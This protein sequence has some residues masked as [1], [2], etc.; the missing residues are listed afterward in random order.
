MVFRFGVFEADAESGQLRKSGVRV[1]LTEQA[2]QVL[3]ALLERPGEVVSREELKQR[4]WPEDTF[5]DFDHSL[6][7]VINKLRDALTDSASS[8]RY[9]ET[10]ARRGYRFL[11][12][13]QATDKLRPVSVE[14]RADAQR[15]LRLPPDATNPT[16]NPQ[17]SSYSL[18][19]CPEELPKIHS[20]H[21]HF[22]FLLIQIMYFTFY[23]VTLAHVQQVDS[24]V[25][26]TFG[27]LTWI[28]GM[29][30]VL[31][32]GGIPVRLYLIAAVAFGIG[33]LT[34][35]FLRMFPAILVLDELWSLAPLLLTGRIGIGLALGA[36]AAL[37][38]VPFSE[39]S[40]VLM[41]GRAK[42]A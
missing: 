36:T 16:S 29:V 17:S 25:M 4:L 20:H 38:Y 23:V 1:R 14:M 5:V 24:T 40:L 26:Q 8:P 33:D 37:V 12:Q 32:L 21:V 7:A 30:L 18:L 31:A 2:F 6:N 22:L 41:V 27:H 34:R 19:T 9:I 42:E 13:V 3:T 39:R 28:G 15:D 10:L 11:V 35:K